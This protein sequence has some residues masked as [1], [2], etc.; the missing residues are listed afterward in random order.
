MSRSVLSS[1][2][3]RPKFEAVRKIRKLAKSEH[4]LEL[5]QLASRVDHA[6]HAESSNGDDP[7]AKVK[8]LISEMISRTLPTRPTV[9]V[10]SAVLPSGVLW[11]PDLLHLTAVS[12]AK[13]CCTQALA[14]NSASPLVFGVDV[15]HAW[16]RN[17]L[18]PDWA[19]CNHVMLAHKRGGW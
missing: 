6:M 13:E 3:G 4:S 8:S 14:R 10:P 11:R 1:R 5:A 2:K 9:R 18:D 16:D 19:S 7:F 15:S 12:Y 17:D